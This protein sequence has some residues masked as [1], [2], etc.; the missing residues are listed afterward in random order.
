M[1]QLTGVLS[2]QELGYVADAAEV[3]GK[4]I[5]PYDPHHNSTVTFVGESNSGP[6][7]RT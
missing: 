4:G 2:L 5:C 6:S 7:G 3:D 1:T